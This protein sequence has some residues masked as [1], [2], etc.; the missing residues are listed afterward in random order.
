MIYSSFRGFA[1]T[2]APAVAGEIPTPPIN[3][4][5]PVISAY[6][7]VRGLL[8]F[9]QALASVAL[10]G[11]FIVHGYA[12]LVW[13]APSLQVP[14]LLIEIGVY[15]SLMGGTYILHQLNRR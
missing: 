9:V 4:N 15:V 2:G 8:F 5:A 7:F 1:P 13:K 6:H 3:P 11:C 10:L 14:Y 12:A